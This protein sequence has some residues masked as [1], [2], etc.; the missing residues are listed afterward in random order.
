MGH[1]SPTITS[2]SVSKIGFVQPGNAHS[3]PDSVKSF[4][5]VCSLYAMPLLGFWKRWR[6]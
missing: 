6:D 5:F 1:I 4:F 2:C 3:F